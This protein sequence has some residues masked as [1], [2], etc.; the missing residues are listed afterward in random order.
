MHIVDRLAARL[1]SF[2]IA[3][4]INTAI[5]TVVIAMAITAGLDVIAANALGYS[6]GLVSSYLINSRVTFRGRKADGTALRFLLAFLASFIVNLLVVMVADRCLPL[7]EVVRGVAGVPAYMI[8]FYILCERWVF[9]T[10]R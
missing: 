5:G 9:R 4:V 2:S 10:G 1:A 6:T 3:G 8:T 7:P